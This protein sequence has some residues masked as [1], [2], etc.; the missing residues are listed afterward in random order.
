M[1]SVG[2]IRTRHRNLA[3]LNEIPLETIDENRFPVAH[4][5]NAHKVSGAKRIGFR[6]ST[7]LLFGDGV[8]GP[9]DIFGKC[10]ALSIGQVQSQLQLIDW[11]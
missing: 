5:S 9:V 7:G 4:R 1:S 10:R 3:S 2:R 11:S 6:D 8:N